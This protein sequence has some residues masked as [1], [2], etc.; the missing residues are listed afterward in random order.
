M[1]SPS[2]LPAGPLDRLRG[3]RAK[4]WFRWSLDAALLV[5][6][7][8]VLGA[9]QTRGHLDRGEA[10]ALVLPSLSGEPVA[11]ASLRGKPTL[12]AVWAPWCSVCRAASDN[13]GRV[14]RIAGLR[15]RVVSIA[16]AYEDEEE[17]RRYVREQGLEHPVLLADDG[18][19]QAL[20]VGAFPTYY[21]L[22]AE[23]RVKGSAAGYTSTLGML[24]RLLP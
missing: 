19:V 14:E 23:G 18:A 21:F 9:W 11:L 17:V 20:R 12:V 10:P 5:A 2:H 24:A 13:L 7:F 16:A 4:R 3:L 15:V 22:D 8:L 1:T 6:V